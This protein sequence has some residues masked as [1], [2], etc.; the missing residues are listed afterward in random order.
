MVRDRLKSWHVE[1]KYRKTI[2]GAA[3]EPQV[4]ID[5]A[6]FSPRQ[7]LLLS[8]ISRW[9]DLSWQQ[10]TT[11]VSKHRPPAANLASMINEFSIAAVIA[12]NSGSERSWK[13]TRQLADKVQ[14]ANLSA[15]D[16]FDVS[17]IPY[18]G[19]IQTSSDSSP[20][21]QK[22]L[23]AQGILTAILV[24]RLQE[25]HPQVMFTR[26]CFSGQL[27]GD[28]CR[29]IMRLDEFKVNSSESHELRALQIA[30]SRLRLSSILTMLQQYA[31]IDEALGPYW[32]SIK[33]D[34]ALP[35]WMKSRL[36]H[37]LA[38]SKYRQG[39]L[40]EADE[41]FEFACQCKDDA[42]MGRTFERFWMYAKCLLELGKVTEAG[43]VLSRLVKMLR[44][45]DLDDELDIELV[46]YDIGALRKEARG[47]SEL[48]GVLEQ[49][50]ALNLE[51]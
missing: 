9:F 15:V 18:Y 5:T 13:I 31:I 20:A 44:A 6:T 37:T 29:A 36:I 34:S 22:T 19:A 4:L 49:F 10:R 7:R 46:A 17:A 42:E 1:P 8:G 32:P 26:E 51:P 47:Y 48:D 45:K 38:T 50:S 16:P 43:D 2:A 12:T 30:R 39:L 11:A 14:Q 24:Q 23:Q 41:L 35:E 40:R 28:L 33:I 3:A 27:H 25:T 21:H